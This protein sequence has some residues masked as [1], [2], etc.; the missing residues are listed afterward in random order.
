MVANAVH[1]NSPRKEKPLVK[2]SCVMLS[3]EILESELFG[4]ERGAFTGAVKQ[5]KGR[6]E[7]AHK[8]SIFLDEVDDIPV[9]LQV[10]L[11][12]ALEEHAFERVES[13]ETLTVDVRLIAATKKDLRELVNQGE[14]REDLFY[15]LN[16]YPITLYTD[17]KT[18][19]SVK[20]RTSYSFPRGEAKPLTG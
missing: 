12:R 18:W 16:I 10:K 14:F 4:H 13:T 8:G 6:F 11:L 2:V 3:K 7:L 9:E 15:R 1:Y 5:K 17:L 19:K 20:R